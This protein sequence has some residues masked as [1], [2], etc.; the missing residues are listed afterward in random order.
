MFDYPYVIE[1][2]S[3]RKG[4]ESPSEE[5]L[6]RFAERYEKIVSAGCGVSVPDNPMGQRR[7]SFLECI[8]KRNLVVNPERVVM[9][10]NTFHTKKELDKILQDAALV[11]IRYLLIVRGDGGEDFPK[12]DPNSIG[13]KHSVTTTEDLIRYINSAYANHF[14]TGA[15]FNPYKNMA[16]E[17]QHMETKIESGARFIV[18]QPLIGRNRHVDD[19]QHFSV[20]LLVEAWMS[21]NIDLFSRSV[22]LQED[23]LPDQYD[24]L[25]NLRQLHT[26]YPQSCVYLALLNFKLEWQ[27]TLPKLLQ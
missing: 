16:F 11:G 15:A 5:L 19:I 12:L 17:R 2:L 8:Q 10:L 1:M 26:A 7:C 4:A 22:G 20:P 25:A 6:D 18:T 23:D 13:G 9:N 27:Q 21:N 3:P 24:P 14:C